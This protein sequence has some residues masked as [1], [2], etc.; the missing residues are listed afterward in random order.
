M[1][2]PSRDRKKLLSPMHLALEIAGS[3]PPTRP[4]DEAGFRARLGCQATSLLSIACID[5][6]WPSTQG[7]RGS[8]AKSKRQQG[9]C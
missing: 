5:C 7:I 8:H 6:I 2:F 4:S 3:A 9:S 1:G